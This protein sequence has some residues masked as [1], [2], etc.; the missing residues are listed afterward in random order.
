[1]LAMRDARRLLRRGR[2]RRAVAVLDDAA[3]ALAGLSRFRL[4]R[5]WAGA[6]AG[7]PGPLLK[8]SPQAGERY[9]GA[10]PVLL[11]LYQAVTLARLGRE[12]EAR[13][14]VGAARRANSGRLGLL[15]PLGGEAARIDPLLRARA[16]ADF[17]ALVEQDF[18]D[19]APDDARR[20]LTLAVED[21]EARAR[22][23][24][25][26]HLAHLD[27]LRLGRLARAEKDLRRAIALAPRDAVYWSDLGV[28]RYRR[29]DA[30]GAE[31][32]LRRALS[33][34]P[35]LPAAALSLGVLLEKNGRDA[36]ALALYERTLAA[37]VADAGL[38][39]ALLEARARLAGKAK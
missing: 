18:A 15:T 3:P 1:W 34:D 22:T 13:E 23:P 36:A 30:P 31:S 27:W 6:K 17:V 11:P 10:F 20:A 37:P 8:D 26:F 25:D 2:P 7:D 38:R 5:E 19:E 9:D 4:L 29:G 21:A 33:L 28:L 32:A 14:R 35:S 39:A 16:D 12:R 24:E